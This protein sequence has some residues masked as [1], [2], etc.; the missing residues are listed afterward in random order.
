MGDLFGAFSNLGSTV[1][2]NQQQGKA[3]EA[4]LIANRDALEFAQAQEA[5]RQANFERAY[6]QWEAGRNELLNRYGLSL[7]VRETAPGPDL[8][9]W[10]PRPH[11][12]APRP[13]VLPGPAGTGAQREPGAGQNPLLSPAQGQTAVVIPVNN[14]AFAFPGEERSGDRGLTLSDILSS[15]GLSTNW[16]DYYTPSSSVPN[17][18]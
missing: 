6:A 5:L 13:H 18:V 7:D 4:E 2:N 16:R 8:M 17:R 9:N 10:T 3:T 15:R 12:D 1:L 11:P 14:E